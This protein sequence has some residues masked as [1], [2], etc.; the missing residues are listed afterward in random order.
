MTPLESV[1]KV[2]VACAGSPSMVAECG[3][4][5]C[6]GGQGDSDQMCYF[7]PYRLGRGRPSVK[8]IRKFCLE[9]MGGDTSLVAAC[10]SM[11]CAVHVFRFGTNPNV[12]DATRA[13]QRE[14]AL[15]QGFGQGG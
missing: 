8:V 4:D 1:R 12:G 7:F 13:R 10:T 15:Q 3:G 2:C 11:E 14:R 5:R 6:L 9:C